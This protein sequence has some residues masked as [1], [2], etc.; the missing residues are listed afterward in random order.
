MEWYSNLYYGIQIFCMKI[1][2]IEIFIP[3]TKE[4]ERFGV[5]VQ[6]WSSV[7]VAS[8][9]QKDFKQSPTY[10]AYCTSAFGDL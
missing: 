9:E 1:D 4:E 3:L 2:G 6:R 5:W 8:S 10:V 7:Y